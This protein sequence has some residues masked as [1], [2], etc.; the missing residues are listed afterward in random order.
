M[1]DTELVSQRQELLAE[2]PRRIS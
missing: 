1:A 2:G